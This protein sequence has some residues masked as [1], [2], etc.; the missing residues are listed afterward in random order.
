MFKLTKTLYS[1]KQ[2]PRDWYERLSSFLIQNNFSK[3][4]VDTTLFII[5][6]E[7]NFLV[8]QIYI[9]D[10][11]LVLQMNLHVNRLPRV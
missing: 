3:G 11:I 10:I 4:N 6:F 9:D 5:N 1:L 2:A 7:N 8:I